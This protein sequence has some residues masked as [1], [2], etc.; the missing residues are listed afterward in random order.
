MS[1]LDS[2]TAGRHRV[3]NPRAAA[4]VAVTAFV[5]LFGT[6]KLHDRQFSKTVD[7]LRES[8]YA[9]LNAEDYRNARLQLNQY[10]SF[11]SSDLDAREKL[12]ALLSTHIRTQP[13][14]EQAFHLNEE[15]LRNDLPQKDLRLNQA[16]I[17][18]DLGKCSDAEAHLK[19]LQKLGDESAEVWYLSAHCA[20]EGRRTEEAVRCYQR[21]LACANPPEQAFDELATLAIANPHLMLDPEAILDQMVLSCN[22]A[23]A[24]RLRAMHLVESGKFT[25]SLRHVWNGLLSA[26]DDVALN[27]ILVH[28]LQL[29]NVITEPQH[30][31]PQELSQARDTDLLRGIRHLAGCVERNPQQT[32]FRVDLA[33]LLWKDQQKSEAMNVLETGIS[34]DSRAFPLHRALLEYLLTLE[35][36]D[37]AA[38]LLG[39]LPASALPKAEF[40]LLNGRVQM[41]RKDWKNADLSF[42]RA[43]AWS[44]PDSALQ[45]RAQLLLAVC[46]SNS[47]DAATAVDAFRTVVAGAPDS[48]AGRL[49][50]ASAWLKSGRKDMAIAEY[51]HLLD[52]PGV[53]A[54]LADLLIQRNLEQPA[55]LRNWNEVAEIV[56][57]G[58]PLITDQTQRTLLQ[59]DLL[60]AS[61]R[62]TEAIARLE[63]A[64]AIAPANA[65]LQR[66][67]AKLNGEMNDELRGRLTQLASEMPENDDVLAALVRLNLG[68]NRP[69]GA[70]AMLENIATGQQNP[71]ESLVLAIRTAERV[72]ALETRLGRTEYHEV[73]QDAT[74]RNAYKLASIDAGYEATLMRIL[75]RQRRTAEALKRAR[76]IDVSQG[77]AIKAS[78]LMA[79]VRYASPRQSVVQDVMRELVSMINATPNSTALRICYADAL[80][81]DD[82][83]ETAA[84]VLEQIQNAPP[85]DG[86]VAARQAW[87]LAVAAG[88]SQKATELITHAVQMQPGNPTFRVMQARVL[89]AAEKYEEALATLNSIEDQQLSQAALT[90]K[91]SALL[92]T[93]QPGE[94]WQ[95]VERIRLDNLR[96]A[97]FPADEELLQ[98]V[99]NRLNQFTTASRT[100]P[101]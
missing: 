23:E 33:A 46:R 67:L 53:P 8:A 74:R 13:A 59:I 40:E 85:D 63:S 47:G 38:R 45:K 55:G 3:L 25:E 50:M 27:A 20:K 99:L 24:S 92:E 95:A 49:G 94:A 88:S 34:H 22:S 12:S 96:D 64:L 80:L 78:A 60:M 76:S 71:A 1:V 90:Y 100:K 19:I 30:S 66:A 75:A 79:L 16:R 101:N 7:F 37:K 54:F 82:H 5:F 18:V 32:S 43:V 87:I 61:G 41:L 81:Y 2:K 91:A 72:I 31:N 28:C 56:R 93:E 36:T 69:E 68:A 48:V 29:N 10:L 51:R 21:A 15:L 35:Q 6:R 83:M 52:V 70:L 11:R 9:S 89:L 57:D 65:A 77:P 39:S 97:M 86:E 17:A 62:I 84:Q 14:L 73:I 42:Q 26:P 58:N 4:I 44:E 98:T